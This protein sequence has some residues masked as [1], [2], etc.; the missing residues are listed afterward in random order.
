MIK[1]IDQ[2]LEKGQDQEAILGE[3]SRENNLMSREKIRRV[4]GKIQCRD[5]IK[6]EKMS[7]EK[8]R[9]NCRITLS[10]KTK[11]CLLK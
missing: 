5:K 9:G 4:L 3:D 11:L 6:E 10:L 7:R 2:D 1:R 8:S